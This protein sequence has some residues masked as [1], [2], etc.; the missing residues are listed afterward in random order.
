MC[1]ANG[2]QSVKHTDCVGPLWV[3]LKSDGG[4]EIRI[5]DF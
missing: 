1:E 4:Y 2:K 3:D 5:A